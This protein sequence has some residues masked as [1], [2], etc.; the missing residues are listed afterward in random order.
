M[1]GLEALDRDILLISEP[2]PHDLQH[3]G[4]E[5]P[6][7]LPRCSAER[8]GS[9]VNLCLPADHCCRDRVLDKW[10]VEMNSAR[11]T[12]EALSDPS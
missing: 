3:V 5:P 6:L 4:G 2:E 12:E 10:I 9:K 8:A 7:L 1:H 11:C